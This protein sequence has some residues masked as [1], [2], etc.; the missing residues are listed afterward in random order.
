M[1]SGSGVWLMRVE[2][3]RRALN[4]A[5]EESRWMSAKF[6]AELLA[7]CLMELNKAL[8]TEE[9]EKAA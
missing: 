8:W 3:R 6:H 2:A 4:V 1:A 7:S 5:L 9:R